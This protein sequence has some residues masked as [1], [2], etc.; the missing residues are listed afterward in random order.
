MKKTTRL[1]K[2]LKKELKGIKGVDKEGRIKIGEALQLYS[3]LHVL[4]T[5]LSEIIL[6]EMRYDSKRNN[7]KLSKK[8]WL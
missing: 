2:E 4:T 8:A 3:I 7:R 5:V 6:K 1:F